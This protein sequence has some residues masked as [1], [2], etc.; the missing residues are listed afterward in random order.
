MYYVTHQNA[1]NSE[2]M[3]SSSEELSAQA[4]QLK[5][6]ISFFKLSKTQTYQ[7]K[8]TEI[9]QNVKQKPKTPA[10]LTIKPTT[11]KKAPLIIDLSD[12]SDLDSGF[13]KY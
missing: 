5:E 1:A 9:K 13:E 4:E 10:D 6:L 7:A 8:K 12:K 2:E 11:I 3:A